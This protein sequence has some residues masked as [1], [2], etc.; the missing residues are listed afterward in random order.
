MPELNICTPDSPA[1]S[2]HLVWFQCSVLEW[3]LLLVIKPTMKETEIKKKD[4]LGEHHYRP[5]SKYSVLF[6][7]KPNI[8]VVSCRLR[9]LLKVWNFENHTPCP[10]FWFANVDTSHTGDTQEWQFCNPPWPKLLINWSSLAVASLMLLRDHFW[11][12]YTLQSETTSQPEPHRA[13]GWKKAG[14]LGWSESCGAL[15]RRGRCSACAEQ[16]FRL[17]EN[18]VVTAIKMTKDFGSPGARWQQSRNRA[19]F[20]LYPM[21]KWLNLPLGRKFNSEF[22]HDILWPFL[23]AQASFQNEYFMNSFTHYGISEIWSSSAFFPKWQIKFQ[24][25]HFQ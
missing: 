1:N 19:V 2:N 7:S 23:K 9:T 12:G 8:Y 5:S 10:L 20:D 24:Q 18:C 25:W 13:G 14:L 3:V 6:K 16:D 4:G 21:P 17:R 22:L 11:Y 15:A